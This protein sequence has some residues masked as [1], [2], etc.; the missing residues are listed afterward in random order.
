M[1]TH[2]FPCVIDAGP[3]GPLKLPRFGVR[4]GLVFESVHYAIGSTATVT[5]LLV[6]LLAPLDILHRPISV[7]VPPVT[8]L[9]KVFQPLNKGSQSSR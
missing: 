3:K 1:D 5:P 6:E 4:L 7:H 9:G 8:C 2:D